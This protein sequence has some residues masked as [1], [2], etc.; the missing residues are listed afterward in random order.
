MSVEDFSSSYN[1]SLNWGWGLGPFRE[2]IEDISIP[3]LSVFVDEDGAVQ[4]LNNIYSYSTDP[5]PI[6]F[7]VP[8]TFSKDNN[9]IAGLN[10]ALTTVPK[11]GIILYPFIKPNTKNDL[12]YYP[13]DLP[14]G[15]Y[16]CIGKKMIGPDG[17]TATPPLLTIPMMSDFEPV[18]DP[19]GG[20]DLPPVYE[21]VP[22]RYLIRLGDGWTFEEKILPRKETRWPLRDMHE[23]R[24]YFFLL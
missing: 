2:N 7:S 13:D 14:S 3:S 19:L 10:R 12:V 18:E 4:F 22:A 23:L 11:Y 8:P 17:E 20:L 5:D 6:E 24:Q 21:G 9:F 16:P 1:L 15:F